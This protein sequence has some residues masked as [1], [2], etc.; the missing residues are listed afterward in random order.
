[1][2]H[3]GATNDCDGERSVKGNCM[4][5]QPTQVVMPKFIKLALVILVVCAGLVLTGFGV[6]AILKL[7]VSDTLGNDIAKSVAFYFAVVV[8]T[9]NGRLSTSAIESCSAQAAPENDVLPPAVNFV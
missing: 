4:R 8:L 6:Y 2:T 9:L 1:M 3:S 7:A 5:A